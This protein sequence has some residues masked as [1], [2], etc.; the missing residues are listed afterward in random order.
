MSSSSHSHIVQ[1]PC[2]GQYPAPPAEWQRPVHWRW[3]SPPNLPR[4]LPSG[5]ANNL[6]R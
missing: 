4:D 1:L 3:R 2:K 5:F 6:L